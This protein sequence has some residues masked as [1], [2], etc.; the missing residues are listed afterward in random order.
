M[1]IIMLSNI[2][3]C[4]YSEQYTSFVNQLQLSWFKITSWP[5]SR[6][7]SSGLRKITRSCLVVLK[8]PILN[9]VLQISENLIHSSMENN[10]VIFAWYQ[11]LKLQA[12]VYEIITVLWKITRSS[13]VVLKEQNVIE[14]FLKSKLWPYG[15]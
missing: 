11:G 4:R 12:G 10:R 7:F 6:L 8:D 14:V 2:S 13:L 1:Y 15:T 5:P 3:L 9:W